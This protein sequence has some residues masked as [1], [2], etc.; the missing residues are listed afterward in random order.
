MTCDF[1]ADKIIETLTMNRRNQ[2]VFT[3][4]DTH[5]KKESVV[6]LADKESESIREILAANIA[7]YRQK[8]KLTRAALAAKIGVTEAAIGQYERAT[9]TPTI[10]YLCRLSN[11]FGVPVDNLVEH[12]K[13]EYEPVKEYRFDKANNFVKRAGLIIFETSDGEVRICQHNDGGIELKTFNG[14]VRTNKAEKFTTLV[15]F[16]SRDDFIVFVENFVEECILSGGG[17]VDIFLEALYGAKRG[18][19]PSSDFIFVEDRNPYKPDI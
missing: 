18:F 16:G 4:E 5:V 15:S 9:R 14:T 1:R 10:D 2:G 12:E 11:V 6:E 7:A 13:G 17:V 3:M 19:L 8:L